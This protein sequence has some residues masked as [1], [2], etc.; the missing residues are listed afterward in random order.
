MIG[1]VSYEKRAAYRV[2]ELINIGSR[3]DFAKRDSRISRR[4]RS[5]YT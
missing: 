1:S 4:Q 3:R 2:Q 5:H